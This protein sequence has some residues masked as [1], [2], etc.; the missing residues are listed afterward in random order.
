[1]TNRRWR[2][3]IPPTLR[4][5]LLWAVVLDGLDVQ[6]VVRARLVP[7]EVGGPASP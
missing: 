5:D 6:Y 1:M 3:W 4:G 2:S 7:V